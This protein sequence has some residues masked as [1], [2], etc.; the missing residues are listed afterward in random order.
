ML[1]HMHYMQ[2]LFNGGR[3]SAVELLLKVHPLFCVQ[4]AEQL[5]GHKMHPQTIIS[6]WR[7]AVDCA[8][9]ALTD[10]CRD[11]SGNPEKFKE[12]SLS[13][14]IRNMFVVKFMYSPTTHL[15]LE[16]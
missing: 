2:Y 5:I 16:I 4:E 10:A 11:N 9:K 15:I 3:I 6:G 8:K 13:F 7:L 14:F 1:L 12:V